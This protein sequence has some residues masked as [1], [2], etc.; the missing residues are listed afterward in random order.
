M[1]ASDDPPSV[2]G[3]DLDPVPA[4]LTNHYTMKILSLNYA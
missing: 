3:T 2:D 4:N 1:L